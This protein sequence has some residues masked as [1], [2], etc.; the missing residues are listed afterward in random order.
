MLLIDSNLACG[1]SMMSASYMRALA[2]K[3]LFLVGLT[4][5]CSGIWI[6]SA[7]LYPGQQSHCKRFY[8]TRSICIR[9]CKITAIGS[10]YSSQRTLYFV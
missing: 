3:G 8:N 10:C 7:D 5:L 6:L 9:N 2:L 4:A 1:P